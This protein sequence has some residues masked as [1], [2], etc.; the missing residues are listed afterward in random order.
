MLKLDAVLANTPTL[1]PPKALGGSPIPQGVWEAALGTRIA[2]RAEP[3]RIDK[4]VLFVR[5]T[6]AAWAN[7]LAL[8]AADIL[9][10]LRERGVEADSLR[11]SVG[12]LKTP[13]PPR[14]PPKVAA[15][16]DARLPRSLEPLVSRVADDALRA[17]VADAAAKSLSMVEEVSRSRAG[18][19]SEPPAAGVASSRRS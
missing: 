6:S 9:S 11:F 13:Q 7:E 19:A 16:R 17:A 5:V 10:Q 1:T 15:P 8:L 14:E 2:R 4:G 18:G 3:V 12:V